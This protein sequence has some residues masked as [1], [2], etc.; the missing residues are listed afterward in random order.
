MQGFE[1]IEMRRDVIRYQ[2]LENLIGYVKD[3]GLYDKS[4]GKPFKCFNKEGCE[5][6]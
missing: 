5:R 2:V 6:T 1:N 4:Y 3:L